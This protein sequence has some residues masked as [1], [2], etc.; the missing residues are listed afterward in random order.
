MRI[1]SFG[2]NGADTGQKGNNKTL[3]DHCTHTRWRLASQRH[4]DGNWV[5]RGVRSS[6]VVQ[7]PTICPVP[8]VYIFV[9]DV[10]PPPELSH[11][12][13][14]IDHVTRQQQ[15]SSLLE[16]PPL[17]CIFRRKQFFSLHHHSSMVDEEF[18]T[19]PSKPRNI[20][21]TLPAYFNRL[22]FRTVNGSLE[23]WNS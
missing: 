11:L 2:R 23:G 17:P 20:T 10:S 7:K 9:P 19:R 8:A 4:G 21:V 22:S 15:R 18:R 5:S 3:A 12:L 13:C 16:T 14:I 6:V 1:C